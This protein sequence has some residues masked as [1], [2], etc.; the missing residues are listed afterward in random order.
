M[1][2]SNAST[3]I[4]RWHICDKDSLLGLWPHMETAKRD[5]AEARVPPHSIR[6]PGKSGSSWLSSLGSK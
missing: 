4:V 2:T 5:A 3:H 6:A 1:V